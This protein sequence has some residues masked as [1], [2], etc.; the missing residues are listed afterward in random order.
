M[1]F[2]LTHMILYIQITPSETYNFY[3]NKTWRLSSSSQ[4]EYYLSLIIH[5]KSTD[6]QNYVTQCVLRTV[7]FTLIIH[8]VIL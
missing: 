5:S 4:D 6:R 8:Y 7:R 1:H 3:E 2:F